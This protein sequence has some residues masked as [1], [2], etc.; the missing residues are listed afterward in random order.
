MMQL[1]NQFR[2]L[3]VIILLSRKLSKE[4]FSEWERQQLPIIN[5]GAAKNFETIIN[6]RSYNYE[7][8]ARSYFGMES[9]CIR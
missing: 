1:I 6:N 8:T 7:I 4:Y 9:A 2:I 3:K 5:T